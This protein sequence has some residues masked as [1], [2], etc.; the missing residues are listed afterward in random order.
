MRVR[1]FF[2][3]ASVPAREGAHCRGACRCI[4]MGNIENSPPAA[5]RAAGRWWAG[6]TIGVRA[7]GTDAN[8]FGMKTNQTTRATQRRARS[9]HC[10]VDLAA[11]L[12]WTCKSVQTIAYYYLIIFHHGPPILTPSN[13]INPP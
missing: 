7:R 13:N 8:L 12:H 11:P 9:Q 1:E 3:G 4:P 2:G 5:A 6:R 10:Q